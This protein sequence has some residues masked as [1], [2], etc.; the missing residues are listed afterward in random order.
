MDTPILKTCK[1]CQIPQP[2][3]E[4]YPVRKGSEKRQPH[5]RLC[6]LDRAAIHRA[7]CRA[8]GVLNASQK[9]QQRL[10]LQVLRAYSKSDSPVCEC[11]NEGHL[12]FLSIDHITGNGTQH[13]KAI[14]SQG[15]AF[16]LWLRSNNFPPGFRVL[17][18]NCNHSHGHYGYCP[19]QQTQPTVVAAPERETPLEIRRLIKEALSKLPKPTIRLVTE[20][21]GLLWCTVQRYRAEFIATGEWPEFSRRREVCLKGHPLTPENTHVR[22]D[23]SRYCKVC[24][25]TKKSAKQAP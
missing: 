23:G 9:T 22:L 4:F 7:D 24:N 10:K 3:A 17:C 16:Y 1:K 18:F 19:H 11:C 2:L 5:C 20:T 25:E 6:S 12:E 21:S 13:R 8:R 14:R 15:T